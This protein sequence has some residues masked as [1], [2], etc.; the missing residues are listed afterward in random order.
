MSFRHPLLVRL[1][2]V[3]A[4][5]GYMHSAQAAQVWVDRPISLPRHDWAF[6]FG[7]GIGHLN[8]PGSPTGVGLNLE[9]AVGA[10]RRF[11]LGIR[12]GIRLGDD[13]R[14][15][16]AD[17]YGRLFDRQTFGTN[18]DHVANPEFRMRIALAT[19]DI[20]ELALEARAFI[21]IEDHSRFGGMFG[22]PLYFHL[23]HRVRLDTGGFFPVV[24]TDPKLWAISVPLDIWI[25]V[26]S[27]LWLGPMTGFRTTRWGDA[28]RSDWSLGFGLGYQITHA[29]DFKTMLLMPGINHE[30]GARNFGV[31]AGIQVRIE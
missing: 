11:E 29:L 20:A 9:A 3:A 21:P 31:G 26:T 7:M 23:G 4:G 2:L 24:F 28:E 15:T 27:S 17:E 13:G 22:V 6:D 1:L 16:K 12:T 30:E 5:V 19:G 14:I 18:Y 10:T 8:A 25:Q